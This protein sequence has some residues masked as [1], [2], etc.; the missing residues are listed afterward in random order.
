MNNNKID[1]APIKRRISTVVRSAEMLTIETSENLV[2]ATDILGKIKSIGKEIREKKESITKPLNEALRNAR[3]L[4]R[5]IE[6]EWIVAERIVK[7]KMIDF[8]RKELEKADDADR[9]LQEKIEEYKTMFANP[10]RA[11]QHLHVD[12]VIDP[13]ETRPRIIKALETAIDKVEQRP[14]KKHGIMPT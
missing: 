9:L 6:S 7:R 14:E 11:A 4:F 10:Y 1:L 8:N 2:N 5:P 13:A 12:D 3:D